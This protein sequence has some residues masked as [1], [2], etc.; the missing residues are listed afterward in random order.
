M[1]GPVFCNIFVPWILDGSPDLEI[2]D[3]HVSTHAMGCAM[4]CDGAVFHTNSTCR[5]QKNRGHTD[6]IFGTFAVGFRGTM[7]IG[8]TCVQDRNL[9]SNG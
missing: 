6:S 9:T 3:S 1:L 4:G 8:T 2:F 7:L 5:R